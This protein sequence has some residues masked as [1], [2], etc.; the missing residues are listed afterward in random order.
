[1]KF[2]VINRSTNTV[3]NIIIGHAPHLVEQGFI[4]VENPPSFVK[5]NT[6]WDGEKFISLPGYA[7]PQIKGL[8]IL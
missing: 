3:E 1:M 5:I 6:K 7:P 2:A 4:L 8:K